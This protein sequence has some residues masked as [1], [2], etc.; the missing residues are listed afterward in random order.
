MT[1]EEL[2][3]LEA[4]KAAAEK[5]KAEELLKGL[6]LTPEQ[7]EKLKGDSTMLE[8]LT[9]NLEA[10]RKANAEA[11]EAR[12]KLEKLEADKKKAEEDALAKKGE[13]E[14][15]YKKSSD[16]LE[17]M[18]ASQKDLIIKKELEV[19][20]IQNGLKKREY[21][22]LFDTSKLTLDDNLNVVGLEEAFK[23]FKEAN[24]ELFSTEQKIIVDPTK[25]KNSNAP[26][27]ELAK[28]KAQAEKTKSP[29]DIAVYL[30]AQKAAK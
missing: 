28:L 27:D 4:E 24:S 8:V 3:K 19:F 9:H 6:K 23:E 13:Y 21:L 10:K 22:K 15:L 29:R 2:A 7:I 25:P 20:S 14:T 1:P 5:A 30:R 16:E 12:E 18:R 17:K 26:T 11:K